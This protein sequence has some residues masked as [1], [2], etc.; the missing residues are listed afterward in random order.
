MLVEQLTTAVSSKTRRVFGVR[1][2]QD[3]R[4]WGLSAE[5]SSGLHSGAGLVECLICW[6]ESRKGQETLVD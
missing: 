3:S 6:L 2:F 1:G 4:V 5:G